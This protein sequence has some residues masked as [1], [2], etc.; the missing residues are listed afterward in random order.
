[1]NLI[2]INRVKKTGIR[3]CKIQCQLA[4]FSGQASYSDTGKLVIN[5]QLVI[6]VSLIQAQLSDHI[7]RKVNKIEQIE[8]PQVI[9][10]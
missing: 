1:M 4:C 6:Y 10:D 5:Y 8:W 7:L 9:F 2:K 3:F